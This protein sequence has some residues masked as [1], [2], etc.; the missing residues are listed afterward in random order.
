M[1]SVEFFYVGNVFDAV[2]RG[3]L[4]LDAENFIVL[5]AGGIYHIE[6]A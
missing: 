3:L 1:M 5:F 2:K 6:Q 4:G